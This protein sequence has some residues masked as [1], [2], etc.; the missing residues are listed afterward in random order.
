M[1][2]SNDAQD[3]QQSANHSQWSSHYLHTQLPICGTF[4]FFT[5]NQIE[6][7]NY[8]QSTFEMCVQKF[9]TNYYLCPY[10]DV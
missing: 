3:G 8:V 2:K 5:Q 4:K 7:Y 10:F 6:R 1:N 9:K